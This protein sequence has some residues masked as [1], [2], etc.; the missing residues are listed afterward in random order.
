MDSKKRRRRDEKISGL[1]K[2]KK[3]LQKKKAICLFPL[4][5]R[6]KKEQAWKTTKL[7]C[8][9]IILSG[10]ECKKMV[11]STVKV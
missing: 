4:T 8:K 11:W 5:F 9:K 2:D 1:G 3:M 10:K 7:Q 6:K